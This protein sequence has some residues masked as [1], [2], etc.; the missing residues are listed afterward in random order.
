MAILKRKSG[1]GGKI[2]RKVA[3]ND[4]LSNSEAKIVVERRKFEKINLLLTYV[5]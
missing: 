3:K 1:Y 5:T 2:E 4:F